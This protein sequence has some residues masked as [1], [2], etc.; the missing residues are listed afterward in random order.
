VVSKPR[1][2]TTVLGM[3]RGAEIRKYVVKE[4]LP[5]CD[6]LAPVREV[7]QKARVAVPVRCNIRMVNQCVC[8]MRHRTRV[9]HGGSMCERD[10]RRAHTHTLTHNT[11]QSV[12]LRESMRGVCNDKPHADG[13]RVLLSHACVADEYWSTGQQPGPHRH[14][15]GHLTPCLTSVRCKCDSPPLLQ[16]FKLFEK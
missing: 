10:K 4:S 7:M 12:A 6:T 2:N 11:T 8:R 14:T 16:S 15:A 5:P 3:E 9:S 1:R 13:Q